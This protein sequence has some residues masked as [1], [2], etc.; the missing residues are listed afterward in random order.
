MV[1]I[2]WLRLGR[3]QILV[4]IFICL[5]E[6]RQSVWVFVFTHLRMRGQQFLVRVCS[7]VHASMKEFSL[8]EDRS[9][10]DI[11]ENLCVVDHLLEGFHS[12]DFFNF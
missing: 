1:K 2:I 10:R 8:V 5:T 4:Q 3:D 6:T 12:E 9:V 7:L 11:L